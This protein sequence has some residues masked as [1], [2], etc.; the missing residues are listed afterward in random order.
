MSKLG[1]NGGTKNQSSPVQNAA[2]TVKGYNVN[3]K[4]LEFSNSSSIFTALTGT[5]VNTAIPT[6]ARNA[7][8][9]HPT[10]WLLMIFL[11]NQRKNFQSTEE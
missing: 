11:D 10:M 1:K 6:E 9:G 8:I 3:C 5:L 4:K 2:T 7:F